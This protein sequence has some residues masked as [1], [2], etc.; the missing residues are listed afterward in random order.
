MVDKVRSKKLFLGVNDTR[1]V[2][3]RQSSIITI[4]TDGNE[5]YSNQ[6]GKMFTVDEIGSFD[7]EKVGNQGTIQFVP[8]DGRTEYSYNFISYDT[9]QNI[10]NYDSYNF[11]N[12]VKIESANATI[13]V[14][15]SS[16][17]YTL[18]S[19]FSSSKF[20][21]EISSNSGNNYEYNEINLVKV[22]SNVFSSEFG[23]I[24]LS[25]N[26][27]L[28]QIGIGTYSVDP[29]GSN[30]NLIFYPNTN[31]IL[32]GNVVAVSIAN[33]NFSATGFRRLK[34]ADIATGN[35]SIAS[36]TNPNSVAISTYTSNYNFSYYLVQITDK[37]NN[38][39]QFSE[40]VILNNDSDSNLIEYGNVYS[41]NN[42]GTFSSNTSSVTELFFT[43]IPNIAV[44][45]TLLQHSAS[46]IQFS[47]FPTSINFKNAE[48]STGLNKFKS[49]DVIF[50]KDFELT[51][52]LI[53]IFQRR[54]DGSLLAS[55]QNPASVDL[56]KDLIYIPNHFFTS[57]EKIVY[58]SEA[59][60]Y[61]NI[62]TTQT[63]STSG[64]G[65][66]RITVSSVSGLS[67]G[68]YF[69]FSSQTYI[70]IKNITS[71]T[72][73]LSSTISS[74]I[75][76][77][78]AV[79]FSRKS[80]SSTDVYSTLGSIGIAQTFISGVGVTNKLSG[81]L[82]AY[83]FNDKL[84]GFC[85]SPKDALSIPPKLINLTSVGVG[86]NHY[87]TATNQNAKAL[88]LIDNIIQ[89]PVV[90]TSVTSVLLNN[91]SLSDSTTYFSGITS[92]FSGDLIKIDNEIMKISSVGVGSTNY[93]EVI[94][95]FMGSGLTT[96]S[97][98][99][100]ITKL[101]GNYNIVDNTIYFSDAPYGPIYDSVNGDINV[102]SSF[103]GRIFIRSG[104]SGINEE[105]YQKNYIFDDI[106]KNFD[107]VSKQ[108]T[109]KSK[110]QNIT[111]ISTLNS[112]ILVNNIFQNPEDDY[113]LSEISSQSKLNFTGTATSSLYDSN[114]A[115][116][117]RGGI[118]VSVGSSAGF[119]YQ[120][121]VSAG[122]TAIVSIAG[123]IQSISIGNSGSGYRK[124]IQ[125]I[126][127]VGV[128]T[129][130]SGTPSIWYIG[131]AT[132]T[133][134][135]IVSVAI[136]NPGTGYTSTNPPKVVFDAPLSYSDLSLVHTSSSSGI[137]SQAKIDIV[138]GQ[139]S[140][141]IDFT[142]KNYGYS[143]N[144]GDTLTV[145]SGGL[146][147]IP[148]D[149][150]K[151]FRPFIV[152]VERVYE[153]SFSGWSIGE[154]QK[155]DDISSLFDGI[156]KKFTISDNGNRFSIISRK[157]SNIDLKSVLLI[158][159]NDVLQEPG[160]S[161][162]FNGGSYIEFSEAPKFGSKCKIIFYKGTP[163]IDVVFSD[164]LETVKIG[165]QLQLY[166][167]DF[168][169]SENQRT[170]NDILLP[171]TSSTLPYNSV[172]VTSNL[173]L[174][175]PLNWCK[176][177]NDVVID[178]VI[179]GKNRVIY[180]PNIFPI[181]NLIQS[182]GIGS[183]QIFVDSV[184]TIFDSKS[185]NTTND[186]ISKIEIIDNTTISGAIGTAIVS[187][188]GTIQSISIIDGGVGYTTTPSIT[189]ANPIGIGT[190]GKAY[191][192]L[193]ISS[194]IVT[195]SSISTPGFGYTFTN[196]PL[197]LIEPPKLKKEF[198]K[199]VSYSGDFGII[200]GIRTTNVGFASTGL[201]FD[202]FIPQSYLRNSSVVT[203]IITQSQIK[204]DY[205]L[206]VSNS[207]IGSGVTSLRRNG[208]IIGI[209]STGIDNI[210]QVISVSTA[211]TDVYGIG[212]TTVTRVVVSI[213]TYSGL[214]GFGN[215]SYFGDYS[216]GLIETTSVSNQYTV[217]SNFGV[218][219]LNSTPIIRRY[220]PLRYLNYN[221]I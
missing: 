211:S 154:L 157:G 176:Q 173:N 125:P 150:T 37:T 100:I 88:I 208:S 82:Y 76:S 151:V 10:S 57:G 78:I 195:S 159:I 106:S 72:V 52:N 36:S 8:I 42:L 189:I 7:V 111:G 99:S 80:D 3:R 65:S 12:T 103:Q 25:T 107:S 196:P 160:V 5:I 68:D 69:N 203:P 113:T 171:D 104:D 81:D 139:G 29:S 136:T 202:L 32:T 191:A 94:R 4:L 77:G 219:G 193:F 27:T 134:G 146:S 63:T 108:Y 115:S 117:P 67:T 21:I 140:S 214:S 201:I 198:V 55:S 18:P 121:L 220:N 217:N 145:V 38:Q 216:W 15:T 186:I 86:N 169:L 192:N 60:N 45:I 156:R 43:P 123:T 105:T 95:P 41:N 47:S 188:A 53:P 51:H 84:I 110:N 142:I 98:N 83:K 61:A 132:V 118:I 126:V 141:V 206:K 190:T 147:G 163:N 49:E 179:V 112:I 207:K 135:N 175:R 170:V 62:L 56:E 127:R 152:T 177:R 209:G 11:G 213:S 130:S 39:L 1:F 96:H 33:T 101:K 137:G 70:P 46:Y 75:N 138:V 199:N 40:I 31:E 221:S 92:F 14:G 58:R 120:P 71:N 102:K 24:T 59:F 16:I 164:I 197:V 91:L 168:N 34:Y 158:F 205:Y 73:S 166:S 20:L 143:Y 144:V 2:D 74:Q 87:V 187:I 174:L 149:T 6:Y 185:E 180:E 9:K 129:L 30:L 182:V 153:D 35:I 85:T 128:Q 167:N 93:I 148:T 204:Q 28:N 54:F 44:D 13:G 17:L 133:N 161:Y 19:N 212:S 109:L 184:K 131:T 48:L 89:S 218:V 50:K 114:N 97:S 165:D 215:S 119:G 162:S 22:G 26:S 181:C 23:R 66:D 183:T 155:L 172:G 124:S 194:G 178:G 79:T 122:G 116:V 210:Y 200:S 90:S 64:V